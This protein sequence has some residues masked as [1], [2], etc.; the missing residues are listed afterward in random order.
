LKPPAV[1]PASHSSMDSYTQCPKKHYHLK[2]MKDVKEAPSEQMIWGIDVHQRCENNIKLGQPLPANMKTYQWALDLVNGMKKSMGV[3]A[4]LDVAITKEHTPTGFWDRD[5][6]MR[7]KI[8]VL[9]MNEAH[10]SAFNGDWKTGK[11]KPN[12]QQLLLS[13]LMCFDNYATLERV[14]TGFLWLA[15]ADPAKRITQQLFIKLDNDTLQ[16]TDDKGRPITMTFDEAWEPFVD[17]IEQMEWSLKHDT[18]PAKP[19]GLCKAW[20]PV[21]SCPHNGKR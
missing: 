7:G 15:E 11:V 18:W 8:D 9:A 12:S 6:W 19:S 4:E 2:I 17:T 20:C 3:W 1:I 21:L 10:T 13:T 16:T 14:K 5:A